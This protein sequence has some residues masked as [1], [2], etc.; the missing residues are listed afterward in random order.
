[1]MICFVF[2]RVQNKFRE[3]M[4]RIQAHAM[5]LTQ[6]LAAQQGRERNTLVEHIKHTMATQV[7]LKKAWQDIID[8]LTHER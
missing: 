7:Q 8:A 2:D 5:G 1:M 6:Q 4:N 3:T